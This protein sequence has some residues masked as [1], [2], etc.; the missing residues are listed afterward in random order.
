MTNEEMARLYVHEGLS[1]H[2]IANR[3]DGCA[4][5]ISRRLKRMGV[6]MRDPVG[7]RDVLRLAWPRVCENRDEEFVAAIFSAHPRGYLGPWFDKKRAAA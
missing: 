4:K 1:T 7:G 2:A 5:N 6:K 3:C